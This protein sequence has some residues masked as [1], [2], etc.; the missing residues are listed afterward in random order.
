MISRLQMEFHDFNLENFVEE[1]QSLQTADSAT[2]G[3]EKIT[4]KVHWQS[5]SIRSNVIFHRAPS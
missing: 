2:N 5:K 1:Y 3:T 4:K